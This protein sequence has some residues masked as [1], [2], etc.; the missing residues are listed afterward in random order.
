[1]YFYSFPK[2][3]RVEHQALKFVEGD[4]NSA[5]TITVKIEGTMYRP[6]FKQ[7]SF[8]GNIEIEGYEFTKP[9]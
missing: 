6:I 7:H 5:E 9:I 2:E 4:P 3:I 8:E 1:M